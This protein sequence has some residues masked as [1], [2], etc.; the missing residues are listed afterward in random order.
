MYTAVLYCVRIYGEVT[1]KIMN[2][3][4]EN[5]LKNYVSYLVKEKPSNKSA[6]NLKSDYFYP[7]IDHQRTE[8]EPKKDINSIVTSSGGFRRPANGSRD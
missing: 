4:P 5:Y 1:D 3:E 2:I 8:G 7:A 6:T